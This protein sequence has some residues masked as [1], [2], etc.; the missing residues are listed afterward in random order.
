MLSFPTAIIAG[1]FQVNL[2]GQ[3]QSGMG[4]TGV[5]LLSDASTI[6]FNPGAMS[7]LDSNYRLSFGANFL[8]PRVTYAQIAPGNYS[9]QTVHNIGTPF[10]FYGSWK[11]KKQ[12]KLSVGIGIYTPFGS[13]MQW[14]DDWLGQFLIREIDLKTIFFQ[15]TVS[16]RINDKIGIGAGFI[17]ATGSFGLRKGV[18]VQDPNMEYGEGALNGKASG[19][20]FNTAIYIKPNDKLS[21]GIDYRSSVKTSVSNGTA[22]FTVPSSLAQYFPSTTFNTTIKLPSVLTIGTGYVCNKWRFA[23]D[24]NYVGWKS[25]DSLV[26]DFADNTE[27]LADIHSARKYKNSFIFRLGA[28]YNMNQKLS[29]RMGTYYDMTPVQDGYLTP[30]TPDVNKLG[31][32][33]GLSYRPT[34]CMSIDVSFL[35]IEGQQR[36]DTNLETEFSG[37]YK[38]R[39]LVPGIGFEFVF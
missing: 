5:G 20:G 33:G 1:G 37:T 19:Y 17:Y 14:E 6:L 31:I 24:I 13:K 28:E 21:I 12:E 10:T 16:Y 36:T 34:K 7:F 15:P 29:L 18:P 23:L 32:T 35:F 26:I 4:H 30:E 22:N 3:K 27:K 38:S 9:A 2:Q 8:F 39:A 11:F 25:Y